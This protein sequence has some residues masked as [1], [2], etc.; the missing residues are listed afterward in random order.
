MNH[1]CLDKGPTMHVSFINTCLLKL[2]LVTSS[3]GLSSV[4]SLDMQPFL[5]SKQ[6]PIISTNLYGCK[7][8]TSKL[9]DSYHH[10]HQQQETQQRFYGF[11][12]VPSFT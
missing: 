12:F 9:Y 6:C 11:N 8:R 5:V 3:S 4:L 1:V 2:D 7:I 10:K